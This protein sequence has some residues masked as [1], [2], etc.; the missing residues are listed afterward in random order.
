MFILKIPMAL[1]QYFIASHSFLHMQG[2]PPFQIANGYS[3]LFLL[4]KDNSFNTYL[5][6]CH[7]MHKVSINNIY[8]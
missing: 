5:T 3:S 2:N 6:V 1:C 7:S 4:N 8:I